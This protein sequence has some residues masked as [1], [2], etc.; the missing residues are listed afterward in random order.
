MSHVTLALVLPHQHTL[1][2]QAWLSN[3]IYQLTTIVFKLMDMGLLDTIWDTTTTAVQ[4]Y[5]GLLV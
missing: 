3:Y 5:S 2:I 4:V 1:P